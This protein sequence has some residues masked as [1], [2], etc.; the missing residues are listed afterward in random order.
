MCKCPVFPLEV[1]EA[2]RAAEQAANDRREDE[3][4]QNR[5]EE[6]EALRRARD[7][8]MVLAE[9]W[10]LFLTPI[11][12]EHAYMQWATILSVIYDS[13]RRDVV[14]HDISIVR[15]AL[16]LEAYDASPVGREDS[17]CET[18]GNIEWVFRARCTEPGCPWTACNTCQDFAAGSRHVRNHHDD[19][20][21]DS[22]SYPLQD[23]VYLIARDLA[24]VK[25]SDEEDELLPRFLENEALDSNRVPRYHRQCGRTGK[26]HIWETAAALHCCQQCGGRRR[27]KM[28]CLVCAFETCAVCD[29]EQTVPEEVQSVLKEVSELDD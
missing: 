8:N 16:T 23:L 6:A 24:L 4:E 10:D 26:S 18:C 21:E 2:E 12:P 13:R 15:E 14:Q 3:I 5:R 20:P 27:V 1:I 9:E 29:F 19:L 17:A 7:E 11:G 25:L 22:D 28:V